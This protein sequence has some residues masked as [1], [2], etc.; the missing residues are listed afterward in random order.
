VFDAHR[1]GV[2]DKALSHLGP[3]QRKHQ[4]HRQW[5]RRIAVQGNVEL[6]GIL[7]E[8]FNAAFPHPSTQEADA[9]PLTWYGTVHLPDVNQTAVCD[10]HQIGCDEVA[11]RQKQDVHVFAAP[12]ASSR[13]RVKPEYFSR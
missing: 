3:G 9:K 8:A 4:P 10:P 7:V 1:C 2:C 11:F 6:K 5:R 13:P 12:P